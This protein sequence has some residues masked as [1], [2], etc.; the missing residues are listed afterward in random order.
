MLEKQS[1][2]IHLSF[3]VPLRENSCTRFCAAYVRFSNDLKLANLRPF[4][5]IACQTWQNEELMRCFCRHS[6][7]WKYELHSTP[8]AFREWSYSGWGLTGLASLN[9]WSWL[10][11]LSLAAILVRLNMSY[12]GKK[13]VTR[14]GNVS[15]FTTQV[16]PFA[17]VKSQARTELNF[18]FEQLAMGNPSYPQ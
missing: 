15:T 16:S 8:W 13:S 1:L 18:L 17:R 10:V 2:G 3:E 6:L 11:A 9:S 4:Y 14:E 12:T 7:V 5:G